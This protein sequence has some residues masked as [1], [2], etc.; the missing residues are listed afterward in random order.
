MLGIITVPIERMVRAPA[1]KWYGRVLLREEV[2]FL[3]CIKF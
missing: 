2:N 1:V 3:T